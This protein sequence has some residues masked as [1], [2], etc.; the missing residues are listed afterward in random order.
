MSVFVR[1]RVNNAI[2]CE[3]SF[4]PTPSRTHLQSPCWLYVCVFFLL[5]IMHC[6]EKEAGDG[7]AIAHIVYQRSLLI[8]TDLREGNILIFIVLCV[9]KKPEAK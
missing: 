1:T 2:L 8:R 3:K 5:M 6:D 7:I 4:G 9:T